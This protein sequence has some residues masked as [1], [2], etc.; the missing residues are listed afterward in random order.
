MQDDDFDHLLEPPEDYRVV[1][2]YSST[3]TLDSR[4]SLGLIKREFVHYG[5]I[6]QGPFH[7]QTQWKDFIP[8]PL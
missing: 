5:S 4:V 6:T 1:F 2:E 7:V 3:L 8:A